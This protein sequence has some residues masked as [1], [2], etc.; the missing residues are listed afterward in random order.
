[1]SW[2]FEESTHDALFDRQKLNSFWVVYLESIR[3]FLNPQCDKL[4]YSKEKFE[5]NSTILLIIISLVFY[6]Y[7]TYKY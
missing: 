5:K 1:M 2:K 3:G 4:E 7:K 6:N